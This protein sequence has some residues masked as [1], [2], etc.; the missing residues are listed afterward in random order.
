MTYRNKKARDR[1]VLHTIEPAC[2]SFIAGY[3]QAPRPE[4]KA[5]VR[6]TSNTLWSLSV[7]VKGIII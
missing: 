1:L 5:L 3:E 2:S 7:G 6:D 4:L